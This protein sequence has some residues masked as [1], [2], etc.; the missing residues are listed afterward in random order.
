MHYEFFVYMV[1]ASWGQ[2]AVG[3]DHHPRAQPWGYWVQHW[4]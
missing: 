3:G 2:P 1:R 4:G